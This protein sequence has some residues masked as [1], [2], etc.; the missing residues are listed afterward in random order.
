MA[1]IQNKKINK[2]SI[3]A[4]NKNM[5]ED[6]MKFFLHSSNKFKTQTYFQD[7]IKV[8]KVIEASK[9]SSKRNISV[10]V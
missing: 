4:S 8:L 2:S 5:F 1:R 7:S 3:V 9:L 6:Q 10:Y